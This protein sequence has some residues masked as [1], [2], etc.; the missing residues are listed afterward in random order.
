MSDIF[1]AV[2]QQLAATPFAR[3]EYRAQTG[4]TN[5]DAAARL[6]EPESGGLTLVAD[7]QIHGHGRKG[8]RWKASP[9]AS[10]LF[11]TILPLEI[12]RRNLWA[13]TFW[14]A[15]CV[16]K[17]LREL[18]FVTRLQWPNDLLLENKKCCGILCVSRVTGETAH[19][20]CGVGLNVAR[21]SRPLESITPAPSYL[22][23]VRR[24]ERATVLGAILRRFADD[25]SLLEDPQ[26]I[27][28]EW[29]RVASLAGT[30]YRLRLDGE[31]QTIEA[32]AE[33]IGPAGE[34]IV[35]E[36]GKRRAIAL[37]DARVLRS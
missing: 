11:T 29:E 4:S 22:S 18:G 7:Y 25:L 28:R 30:R 15:L 33:A 17:A 23:D 34:L 13:L 36:H 1:A 37:A 35:T 9:G 12:Q 14:I 19:V 3:I 31:S 27:A 26:R 20:A 10:L 24:I 32:T 16:S 8:R 6:R 21:P 5:E 2:R